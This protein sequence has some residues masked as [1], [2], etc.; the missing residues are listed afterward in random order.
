MSKVK[1][2]EQFSR[3]NEA[4]RDRLKVEIE[5]EGYRAFRQLIDEFKFAVKQAT[6]LDE[7]E[8]RERIEAAER[9][10]P[11]P[12]AFSPS[13]Q[14]IWRELKDMLYWKSYVYREVPPKEREGEW[15]VLMD[16]PYTNQEVVCYPG[17]AF[18]EAAYLFAYF[19][20]NLEKN[21]YLR[22]QKVATAI[23]ENGGAIGTG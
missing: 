4:E 14:H 9:L 6:D 20:P 7:R 11:N 16:N 19:R 17:L 5:Q 13:W 23:T 1:R 22:L 21:E 18:D 2:Y 12:A 15:Q 3:A 10:F 8:V